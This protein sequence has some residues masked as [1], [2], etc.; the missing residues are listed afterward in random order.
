MKKLLV[1]LNQPVLVQD[2][3]CEKQKLQP[4]YG[5]MVDYDASDEELNAFMEDDIPSFVGY[6]AAMQKWSTTGDVEF[7]LSEDKEWI[8][9]EGAVHFTCGQWAS[10]I[11]ERCKKELGL[12]FT[13]YTLDFDGICPDCGRE[14]S[15]ITCESLMNKLVWL[16]E[17]QTGTRTNQHNVILFNRPIWL[18]KHVLWPGEYGFVHIYGVTADRELDREFLKRS[19]L[20][21]GYLAMCEDVALVGH[22]PSGYSTNLEEDIKEWYNGEEEYSIVSEELLAEGLLC[23]RKHNLKLRGAVVWAP[24]EVLAEGVRD[25]FIISQ[26]L[27]E[28][29]IDQIRD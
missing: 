18:P 21:L 9:R 10:E 11:G 8:D 19:N 28:S 1:K 23:Q 14:R 22:T 7:S 15:F 2:D 26:E 24:E 3:P 25:E 27:Y 20:Y 5:F 16:A 13:R 17:Q 4:I 29:F 12:D 6:L